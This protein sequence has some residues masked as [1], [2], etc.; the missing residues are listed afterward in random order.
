[1][2]SLERF[3]WMEIGRDN[4]HGSGAEPSD[5]DSCGNSAYSIVLGNKLGNGDEGIL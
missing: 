5:L 3:G 2:G 4:G 1:M